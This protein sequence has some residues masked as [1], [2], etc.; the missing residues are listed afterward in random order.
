MV[1]T[2]PFKMPYSPTGDY[3]LPVFGC[4][5]YLSYGAGSIAYPVISWSQLGQNLKVKI[6]ETNGIDTL[7]GQTVYCH[8]STNTGVPDPVVTVANSQAVAYAGTTIRTTADPV[9]VDG[10]DT[11]V[12]F[13]SNIDGILGVVGVWPYAIDWKPSAGTQ[14]V[15]VTALGLNGRTATATLTFAVAA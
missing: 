13:A 1:F 3:L 8:N 12:T 10:R 7:Y 11:K 14:T 5:S 9:D 6:S 15:T 2:K 4:V